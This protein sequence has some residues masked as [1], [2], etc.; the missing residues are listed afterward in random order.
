MSPLS[1]RDERIA[2]HSP[3]SPLSLHTS[4]VA[5]TLALSASHRG[6]PR[7]I[8]RSRTQLL[9]HSHIH[10]H[11]LSLSRTHIVLLTAAAP[12]VSGGDSS[13]L[14]I[15]NQACRLLSFFVSCRWAGLDG[16]ADSKNRW[17]NCITPASGEEPEGAAAGIFSFGASRL[18]GA[19][20]G[21][22]VTVAHDSSALEG[23]CAA[24]STPFFAKV[25]CTLRTSRTCMQ[26]HRR[27]KV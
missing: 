2:S 1:R 10:P 19:A 12:I 8:T 15:I 25:A 17:L 20:A 4:I 6:I 24:D 7:F 5:I 16:V 23:R 14:N 13:L 18:S 21:V 26:R 27:R 11:T 3:L 9:S 22:R